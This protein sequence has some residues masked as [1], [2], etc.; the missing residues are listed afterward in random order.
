MATMVCLM[1]D[2]TRPV[3]TGV[4][5]YNGKYVRYM[6][7][8]RRMLD[9]KC[10]KTAKSG[11]GKPCRY[12]ANGLLDGVP[13]CSHHFPPFAPVSMSKPQRDLMA[14]KVVHL[15]DSEAVECPVCLEE[16]AATET[17]MCGHVVCAPCCRQM[18]AT[19][20]TLVCPLCRDTR[21]ASL[22]ALK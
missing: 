13:V 18:K 3:L 17:A 4:N 1:A 22:V 2:G 11:N 5:M 9:V 10:T 7:L 21:F 15:I 16:F 20:R 19:G 12:Y 14:T 6:D 8:A